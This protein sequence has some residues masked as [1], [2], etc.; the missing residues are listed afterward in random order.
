MKRAINFIRW[1]SDLAWLVGLLLAL[2][3][4]G[5]YLAM[6]AVGQGGAAG[7]GTRVE[8]VT[9]VVTNDVGETQTVVTK[10]L[11]TDTATVLSVGT[12]VRPGTTLFGPGETIRVVEGRTIR[13]VGPTRTNTLT[14]TQTA[15][16]TRVNSVTD[17]VTETVTD[18]IRDTIT[19]TV[20]DTVTQT[21]TVTVVET[22]TVAPGP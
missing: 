9:N 16:E 11:V 1:K 17:T 13:V 15:T 6:A 4:A 5:A 21:D 12:V 10:K 2:G 18:T 7:G 8:L 22:V 3:A 19:E 20:T 14:Q